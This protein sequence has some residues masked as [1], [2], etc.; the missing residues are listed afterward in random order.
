MKTLL[1][2][3]CALGALACSTTPEPTPDAD[4]V[5]EKAPEATPEETPAPVAQAVPVSPDSPLTAKAPPAPGDLARYISDM[6]GPGP[7]YATFKLRDLGDI[8]CELYEKDAP[9]TVANFVGLARG[10]KAWTDPKTGEVKSNAPYYD[11]VIFHRVIPEFMI[12]GGDPT[13]VGTGGPGYKFEDEFSSKR[14]DGP[15]ILSM[16]NAGPR[17]NGSQFFITHVE[18]PWLD[19]K[20]G[21]FGKVLEGQDIVD[22][23]AQ[24]DVMET[25]EISD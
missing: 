16:A 1:L 21:V 3:L 14:H 10:L 9:M 15:G 24:G 17:T 4:P 18:T 6:P 12:Q 13:G 20:H 22:A 7:L 23:I 5:E 25:V 11:G 8:R 2:S 19:G